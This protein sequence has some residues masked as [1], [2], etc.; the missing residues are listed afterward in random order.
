MTAPQWEQAF[1]QEKG[2]VAGRSFEG[3]SSED[4]LRDEGGEEDEPASTYAQFQGESD[5]EG[6][7]SQGSEE[8]QSSSDGSETDPEADSE[9]D[10]D[11]VQEKA[12]KKRECGNKGT[13]PRTGTIKLTIFDTS[14][15][16]HTVSE[17][18]SIPFCELMKARKALQKDQIGDDDA[19]AYAEQDEWAADRTHLANRAKARG[20]SKA[21]RQK[22]DAPQRN[23]SR[24]GRHHDKENSDG[25]CVAPKTIQ[26]RSNK[27]APIEMSSC[28]AV[29]RKRSVV[30]SAS[31]SQQRRDPRFSTLSGPS[32]NSGMFNKS[33]AF[34]FE[35]QSKELSTLRQTLAKLRKLEANHAG[36]KATSQS[37]LNIRRERE[38]IERTLKREEAKDAERKKRFREQEVLRNFR[39]E[40][41]ER[42]K[43][44]GKRFY[45]KDSAKRE[46][47][48]R[49]KFSRLASGGSGGGD[50]GGKGAVGQGA[51]AADPQ[52]D[53]SASSS[54]TLRKA[55][56]KRRKKNAAKER[57]NMP[58][59]EAGR[60]GGVARPAAAPTRKRT[61]ALTSDF[62]KGSAGGMGD[63]GAPMKRKR[64][65]RGAGS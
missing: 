13:R 15:L 26:S 18:A 45:L 44:G 4:D 30:E 1:S 64:G 41:D 24:M 9:A 2:S 60:R 62:K 56:D 40:N 33:Y 54:K 16:L 11:V 38:R 19:K 35:A 36:P 58:F 42:V 39:R 47:L 61:A 17:L 46:L 20:Q 21:S 5:F 7:K 57:K 6:E 27:H 31:A 65:A 55:L 22:G 49:D 59:L 29:S 53:S 8:S 52:Q 34:L 14:D 63:S 23:R 3:E 28:K 51:G 25:D 12:I 48:L 32:V 50:D 43:K 10:E 37:A